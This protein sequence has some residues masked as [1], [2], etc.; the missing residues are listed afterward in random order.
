MH[1]CLQ[2]TARSPRVI[3]ADPII[4]ILVQSPVDGHHQVAL[5]IL[6]QSPVTSIIIRCSYV[7]YSS[8][9]F[10][11]YTRVGRAFC[12]SARCIRQNESSRYCHDVRLFVRLS[13]YRS[14]HCDYSVNS[15]VFWGP[16]HQS[17]STYSQPS[18][19]IP[20]GREVGYGCANQA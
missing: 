3:D 9:T 6:H 18:Y 19:P 8:V 2:D 1:F 15:S 11:I 20:P 5:V 17:M 4:N 10:I 16:R 12:F 7:T 13:I 14:V